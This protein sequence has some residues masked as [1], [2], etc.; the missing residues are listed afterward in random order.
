MNATA[1]LSALRSQGVQIAIDDDQIALDAPSGVLT[2]KVLL[3]VG[4][5]KSD[6]LKVLKNETRFRGRQSTLTAP[7]KP[8]REGATWDAAACVWRWRHWVM[9]TP[10]S[11]EAE[12]AMIE[13]AAQVFEESEDID[14]S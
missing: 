10:A 2:P 14:F 11:I 5:A 1:L 7:E 8:P 13:V 3:A 4:A 12:R 9:R 6:L